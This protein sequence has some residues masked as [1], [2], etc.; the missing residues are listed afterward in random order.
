MR[1]ERDSPGTGL[2]PDGHR[3]TGRHRQRK[4]D[5]PKGSKWGC[6]R[7]GHRHYLE[8][9]HQRTKTRGERREEGPGN[10][11]QRL[12]QSQIKMETQQLSGGMGP[13]REEDRQVGK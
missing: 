3:G 10:E 5:K 1:G 9:R 6:E 13:A 12:K 2:G 4:T 11:A 8:V 7:E